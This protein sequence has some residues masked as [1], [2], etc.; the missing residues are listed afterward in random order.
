MVCI[1]F[2]GSTQSG[3]TAG[4][5]MY[6]QSLSGDADLAYPST[7]FRRIPIPLQS[8]SAPKMQK[9]DESRNRSWIIGGN[10]CLPAGNLD[11]SLVLLPICMPIRNRR[12]FAHKKSFA[13]HNRR[14]HLKPYRQ[15]PGYRKAKMR[16]TLDES[17]KN[18]LSEM[19]GNTG[20]EPVTP[21]V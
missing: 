1:G 9:L 19:V 2:D 14:P 11:K 5:A 15:T 21:T 4:I 6:R 13:R 3:L 20:L 8:D 7:N 16:F 12:P 17:G 18:A 10:D